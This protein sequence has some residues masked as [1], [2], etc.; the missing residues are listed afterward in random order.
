[1]DKQR[2]PEKYRHHPDWIAR[3]ARAA[4]ALFDAD[5][6][7]SEPATARLEIRH[8]D[9][10]QGS[11]SDPRKSRD[12]RREHRHET[13]RHRAPPRIAGPGAIG[14]FRRDAPFQ[15]AFDPIRISLFRPG[16]SVQSADRIARHVAAAR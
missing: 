11:V 1:N 13:G 3:P 14:E 2:I 4:A 6:F 12:G 5:L 9:S 10:K 16:R 15:H 8:Y 7:V